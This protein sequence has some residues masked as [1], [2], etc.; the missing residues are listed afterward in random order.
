MP[1]QLGWDRLCCLGMCRT[2]E[3]WA[4]GL[5][6]CAGLAAAVRVVGHTKPPPEAKGSRCMAANFVPGSRTG[7]TS[8]LATSM[9]SRLPHIHDQQSLRSMTPG[10]ADG[11]PGCPV[12]PTDPENSSPAQSGFLLP[13]PACSCTTQLLTTPWHRHGSLRV[14]GTVLQHAPAHLGYLHGC[15]ADSPARPQDEHRLPC[16]P[17]GCDAEHAL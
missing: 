7:S 2:S 5:C 10:A 16:R 4:Q 3:T 9:N 15:D 12:L 1:W 6:L 14:P 13:L 8:A 11:Q 17:P